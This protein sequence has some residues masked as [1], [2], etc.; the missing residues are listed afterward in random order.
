MHLTVTAEAGGDCDICDAGDGS[1]D[2]HTQT[3]MDNA[4]SPLVFLSLA[5]QT[6]MFLAHTLDWTIAHAASGR[7]DKAPS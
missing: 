2:T 1:V 4:S 3:E 5:R 7:S 6:S